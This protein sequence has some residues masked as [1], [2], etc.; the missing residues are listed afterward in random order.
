VEGSPI[1][2]LGRDDPFGDWVAVREGEPGFTSVQD[3]GDALQAS[4]S[5]GEVAIL[6]SDEVYQ[7]MLD[8]HAA[9]LPLPNRVRI[10]EP[11]FVPPE[12]RLDHRRL[13]AVVGAGVGRLGRGRSLAALIGVATAVTLFALGH[14]LA[15]FVFLFGTPLAIA[16][17]QAMTKRAKIW[18]T[19][20]RD[21]PTTGRL[22]APPDDADPENRQNVSFWTGGGVVSGVE[23][24]YPLVALTVT[25]QAVSITVSMLP[26]AF[27]VRLLPGDM[28]IA[29]PVF[30]RA[31]R[32]TKG[33]ALESPIE[34]KTF[35]WTMKPESVL[36]ALQRAGYP[37]VWAE[38]LI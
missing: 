11:P 27:S 29:Y 15:G 3:L 8:A 37:V 9:W 19:P 20:G 4:S 23:A 24:S 26:D 13:P 12:A 18:N 34:P 33:I 16:I 5:R 28:T 36:A 2:I 38:R 1:R 31:P 25:P 30:G 21:L 17:D 14:G 6:V 7:Q 10:E 22:L 35:F 32:F